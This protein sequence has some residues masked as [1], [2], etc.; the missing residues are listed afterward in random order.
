MSWL[1][2]IVVH[3]HWWPWHMIFDVECGWCI[4]P[5]GGNW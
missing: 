4:R 2:H 3:H 5:R 1:K